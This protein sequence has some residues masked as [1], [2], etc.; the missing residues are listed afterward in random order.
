[1]PTFASSKGT[2]DIWKTS[3]LLLTETT[4]IPEGWDF[5]K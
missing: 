4:E 1:M 2:N 3:D 5:K